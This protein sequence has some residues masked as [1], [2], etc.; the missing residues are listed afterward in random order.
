M[1]PVRVAGLGR[2]SEERSI[3]I[4][5]NT[6]EDRV[7]QS[8]RS[9]SEEALHHGGHVNVRTGTGV[10]V[11][12]TTTTLTTRPNGPQRH[13]DH[14]VG[15]T[16]NC[17]HATKCDHTT[18]ETLGTSE[19]LGQADGLRIVSKRDMPKAQHNIHTCS[20]PRYRRTDNCA[21]VGRPQAGPY[22]G[23][24]KRHP[25]AVLQCSGRPPS[26]P[27]ITVKSTRYQ[28]A[29]ENRSMVGHAPHAQGSEWCVCRG[30]GRD[31]QTSSVRL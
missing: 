12:C 6:P 31:H 9:C 2:G 18:K 29:I 30:C 7:L 11:T 20:L 4:S 21:G 19:S 13:V 17:D 26:R 24:S 8:V 3:T 14:Q 16:T 15:H 22:Q 27:D 10:S 28:H 23:G 1:P 5:I 25:P